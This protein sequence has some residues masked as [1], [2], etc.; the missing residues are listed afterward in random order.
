MPIAAGTRFGPYAIQSLLGVGGM[1]E[2]YRARDERLGRDVAIKVL[3]SLWT[4]DPDRRA[5]FDREARAL[6][7]LNHP[8]IGA[9]YGLEESSGVPGAQALVLELVEGETLDQVCGRGALAV[10]DALE[11]A[12]QIAEALDAAHEKGIIHRDL[13]PANVKITP[14]GLVKVLDFG[15]AKVDED[16]RDMTMAGST[17][18]GVILGT[19]AYM[20]PEQARGKPFDKRIDIW[21]FGC[22]LYEL[23]AG[24]MPFRRETITGTL[25]AIIEEEPDWARLPASTP[26]PVQRLLRRCLLKD[27]KRRL[28]DI[29]DARADL[30]TSASDAGEA[31]APAAPPVS[32][33]VFFQRLTD[34][35][36]LNESPA[37]SPDG[38]MVAFVA[39]ADGRQH[40]W[41]L[42]LAGGPPL[43]ITRDN[44]D[45]Q[46]PR[47]APDSSSIIYFTPPAQAGEDGTIWEVSALGG[48]PKPATSAQGPG[49]V[50]HDGERIAFFQSRGADTDLVVA[51]R[52]GSEPR[53]VAVSSEGE[54]WADPRWSPDDRTIAFRAVVLTHFDQ[55]LY[56]IAAAG[57]DPRLLA[58]ASAVR[59]LAWLGDGSGLVYSSSFGSTLP[60]PPTCNLRVVD[61][62]GSNDRQLTF[63]DLS[64]LQPDVGRD[65]R[66]VASRL[67]TQ[68]DIWKIPAD[69]TALENTQGATRITRQTG[70]VQTPSI[71]PDGKEVVYL[72]DNS[73]H[74]NLWVMALDGGGARQITFERDPA[75]TIGVPCWSP[76]GRNI[77]YIVSRGATELWLVSPQG[78]GPRQLV[79][80]GFGG[81]WSPDSEW[82][83]YSPGVQPLR[84][85]ISKIHVRTG[86]VREVRS[87]G[88]APFPG[89][90]VLFHAA[91]LDLNPGACD[92]ELRT[93]SPED[94]PARPLARISGA[95]LPVNQLFVH[96]CLSPDGQY[97][98]L[99]LLDGGTTNIWLIS[100]ADGTMRPATDF[101]G[102]PVL[103]ARRV[104]WSPDSR[105]I[106]AA[107]ADQNADIVVLDGLL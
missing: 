56:A 44:E 104:S 22:V 24:H 11:V 20:S 36:G 88:T 18:A 55:R 97:L 1:G 45:H 64:Y 98:A 86:E 12:R 32:R 21:A 40:I 63:G 10:A 81:E 102:R 8:N 19:P 69:G 73:G 17:Q 103:I 72:S 105:F 83:Y 7:S 9:I 87:D 13:K 25:A 100:T 107:V 77:S 67:R 74:G 91:R 101:G 37:I 43:R 41:I 90:G 65:G 68:S 51:R 46:H 35:T 71:S 106:F 84:W 50:S 94:G 30:T 96:A 42:L 80:R 48:H 99:P 85:I 33:P 3:P 76:N 75:V 92:W 79:E 47:W 82:L 52:D 57:G 60:Y 29:G 54:S 58:R 2:V 66:L 78:R 23:L 62:D 93:A 16:E 6:A 95:R 26:A 53:A 4:I 28:R 31:P 27:P 34:S 38:K 59:G 15:L 70:V 49:D 5:R 14:D 89:R 39:R 61:R